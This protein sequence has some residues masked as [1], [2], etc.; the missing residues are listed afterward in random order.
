M[1]RNSPKPLQIGFPSFVWSILWGPILAPLKED[2]SKA[3]SV[4]TGSTFL[5]ESFSLVFD[6]IREFTTS[7][8]Q[9]L[10]L[11][12]GWL[13]VRV[14]FGCPFLSVFYRIPAPL[15]EDTSKALSVN[16]VSTFLN[17]SYCLLPRLLVYC[18][19]SLSIDLTLCPLTRICLLPRRFVYIF[20]MFCLLVLF[21]VYWHDAVLIDM[22]LCLLTLPTVN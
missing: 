7:V 5:N 19:D 22:N 10:V 6:G 16:T 15:N 21:F 8:V 14:L 4:N 12:C 11:S 18:H 13:W 3:L 9:L 1:E 17:E 20:T 2:T